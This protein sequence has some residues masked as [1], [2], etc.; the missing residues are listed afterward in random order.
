MDPDWFP[1]P[2][3]FDP[4]RFLPE[5]VAKRH[6]FAY[7]PFSAGPRN[8]IGEC[9]YSNILI[10]WPEHLIELRHIVNSFV[11]LFIVCIDTNI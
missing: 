6:P 11:W 9:K 8:C 7:V 10:V 1:D 5:N 2:E 4:D 3:R